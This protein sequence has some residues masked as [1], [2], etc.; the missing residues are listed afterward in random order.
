M[1]A[2]KAIFHISFNFSFD[3]SRGFICELAQTVLAFIRELNTRPSL[4]T[5]PQWFSIDLFHTLK[6]SRKVRNLCAHSNSP[7]IDANLFKTFPLWE[8]HSKIF[9]IMIFVKRDLAFKNGRDWSERYT[10]SANIM[11]FWLQHFLWD[12]IFFLYWKMSKKVARSLWLGN[13]KCHRAER[14]FGKCMVPS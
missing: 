14:D 5:T 3:T 2:F 1:G 4:G 7:K 12:G 10:I 9:R 11:S 8:S 13:L 6:P